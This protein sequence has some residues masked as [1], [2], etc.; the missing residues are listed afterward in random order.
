[1]MPWQDYSPPSHSGLIPRDSGGHAPGVNITENRLLGSLSEADADLLR[2]YLARVVL[3]SGDTLDGLADVCFPETAIVSF[4]EHLS[5]GATLSVGLIGREGMIGWPVL[6]GCDRPPDRGTVELQGG[7]VLRIPAAILA[8]L[9]ARH[10]QLRDRLLAFVRTYTI[11]MA[12]TVAATLVDRVEQR[13][14]RWLLMLHDRID[15]D[16]LLLTHDRLAETL[17][18]RRASVTDSLH[19]LEGLRLVRCSRGHLV[20]RDRAGL[21][22]QA[23]ECYGAAEAAY[24]AMVAPFGKDEPSP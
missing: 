24:R 18:V 1:M 4:A 6:L 12:R 19:V 14:A 2:P 17:H 5:D 10:P 22:E 15:G 3:D 9:C 16:E 23:G 13:L 20:V 21:V 11:Q 8:D 7:T